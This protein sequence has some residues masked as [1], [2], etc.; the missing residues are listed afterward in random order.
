M[1]KNILILGLILIGTITALIFIHF[2]NDHKECDTVT[3]SL[4]DSNGTSV[5]TEEH[6]CKER[7]NF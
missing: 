3:N 7:Y 4:T 1:K 2:S 6:I 5:K